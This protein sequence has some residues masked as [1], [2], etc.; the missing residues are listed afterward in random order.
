MLNIPRKLSRIGLSEFN[1]NLPMNTY[2]SDICT[3]PSFPQGNA[4][5]CRISLSLGEFYVT[6]PKEATKAV[7]NVSTG[8]NMSA[9]GTIH[10]NPNFLLNNLKWMYRGMPRVIHNASMLPPML[11]ITSVTVTNSFPHPLQNVRT[12]AVALSLFNLPC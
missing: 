7:L 5:I 6:A 10:L 11:G 3:L 8:N 4:K 2:V 9:N 1:L 12:F